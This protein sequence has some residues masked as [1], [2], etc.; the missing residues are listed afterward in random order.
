MLRWIHPSLHL[1]IHKFKTE[2]Q[3]W[4]FILFK[5]KIT[6]LFTGSAICGLKEANLKVNLASIGGLENAPIHTARDAE[7]HNT[8]LVHGIIT[9]PQAQH[10]LHHCIAAFTVR[11]FLLNSGET[12]TFPLQNEEFFAILKV[13]Y[14]KLTVSEIL[15][16]LK[17]QNRWKKPGCKT[18]TSLG[19]VSAFQRLCSNPP[20]PIL[21]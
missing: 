20:S 17:P 18:S 2:Y 8:E 9:P 16:F 12:P 6:Q 15:L 21:A 13:L 19:Y 14:P 10:C 7:M 4:L 11:I 5:C 3:C 1:D